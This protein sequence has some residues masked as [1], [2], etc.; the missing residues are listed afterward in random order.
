M[1]TVICGLFA[2]IMGGMGIGGGTVLIPALTLILGVE[3]KTA[4]LINLLCFLPTAVSALYEHRKN[5]RIETGV[6]K[7]LIISGIIGCAAGA[8]A[9]VRAD[10]ALL[11]RCFG[12]F[13]VTMG[14][15]ELRQKQ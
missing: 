14:I 10:N 15:R 1:L 12:A 6:L 4:Q 5:N 11:K 9:A 13:L 7:I 3:Q 2:G 8:F